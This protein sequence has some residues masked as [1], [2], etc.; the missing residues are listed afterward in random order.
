MRLFIAAELPEEI[1]DA[2]LDNL[3]VPLW[4]GGTC[5]AYHPL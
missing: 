4:R 3:A 1:E 5:R 2:L